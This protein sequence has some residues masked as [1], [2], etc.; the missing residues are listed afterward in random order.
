MSKAVAN[1]SELKNKVFVLLGAGSEMGPFEFLLEQGA[2]VMAVRTRKAQAW[3]EMEEFAKKTP[4]TLIIPVNKEGV[5]G[6]DICQEPREIRDWVLGNLPAG[7]TDLTVGMYTYLD[8]EAH[9]RVSLGCDLIMQGIEKYGSGKYKTLRRAYLGSPSVSTAVSKAMCDASDKHRGTAGWFTKLSMA[10]QPKTTR[11]IEGNEDACIWHGYSSLQGPNYA[12]AKC[13][14]TWSGMNFDGPVAFSNGPF[15]Y[16]LSVTHNATAKKILDA[17]HSIPPC[18]GFQANTARTV[19]ALLLTYDT[20]VADDKFPYHSDF[21][22]V[23]Q[24]GCFHGGVLRCGYDYES[25]K[26]LGATMLV[27]GSLGI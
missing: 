1:V 26:I 20:C 12:L 6:A 11:G 13:L 16:T 14:Q 15:T 24:G 3:V 5:S 18:E 8:G 4:G 22:R 17:I 25:S 10:P 21:H 23:T 7:T 9:V 2:T 27:R 19:L